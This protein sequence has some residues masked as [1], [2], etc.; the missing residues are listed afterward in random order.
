MMVKADA[1]TRLMERSYRVKVSLPY[2]VLCS[3]F[4][5]LQILI[6]TKL[7]SSDLSFFILVNCTILLL[8]GHLS[9]LIH[10]D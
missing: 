3:C 4:F 2:P 9:L 7:I 5:S 6:E 10:Y 1:I 8:T